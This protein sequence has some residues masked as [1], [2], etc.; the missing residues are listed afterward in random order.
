[1]GDPWAG[2]VSVFGKASAA[3]SRDKSDVPEN[4]GAEPPTGSTQERQLTCVEM[5]IWD[6]HTMNSKRNRTQIYFFTNQGRIY[7]RFHNRDRFT[8]VNPIFGMPVI[9]FLLSPKRWCWGA[10]S[11]ASEGEGKVGRSV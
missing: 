3:I 5:L 10:L 9:L 8:V 11:R 6:G 7:P 4:L 1:M 2:H